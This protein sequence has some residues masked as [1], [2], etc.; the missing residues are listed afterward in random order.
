M[1]ELKEECGVAA[2]CIEDESKERGRAVHFLYRILLNLQ[3][4][5]QLSAGITTYDS[6]RDQLIDTYKNLGT[7]NEV[8]KTSFP[9]LASK[10]FARYAA[11]KGIGHV[12]Y[13]T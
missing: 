12:R 7:V 2:V 10:I 9:I 13:A 3:H 6:G 5:G 11:N 4:R 1:D 8:F